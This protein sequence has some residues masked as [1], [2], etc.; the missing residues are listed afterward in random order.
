[1][2]FVQPGRLDASGFRIQPAGR[3]PRFPCSNRPSADDW[4]ILVPWTLTTWQ[5]KT[6]TQ[7]SHLQHLLSPVYPDCGSSPTSRAVM[8]PVARPM[9]PNLP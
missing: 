6:P 3:P 2:G 5:T 4:S 1:M 7:D 9:S 8:E